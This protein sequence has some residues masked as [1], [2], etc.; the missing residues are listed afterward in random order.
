M[1]GWMEDRREIIEEAIVKKQC[2]PI[3][4]R[5]EKEETFITLGI[6]TI[7]REAASGSRQPYHWILEAG[8]ADAG[9]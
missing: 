4:E 5:T 8:D 2:R 7:G 3:E 9:M 6:G 1:D